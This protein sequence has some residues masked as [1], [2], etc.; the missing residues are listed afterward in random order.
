M[1]DSD[2]PLAAL[3]C[4]MP[5]NRFS[6]RGA[7]LAFG[8]KPDGAIVHIDD[9]ERGLACGCVCAA[10]ETELVAHRGSR[11]LHHFAH[12]AVGECRNAGETALHKYAKQLLNKERRLLLPN[13]TAE[14]GGLKAALHPG[15]EYR[16]DSAV[17]E[18]RLTGI[19]PDVIVRRRKR[20]LLVEFRVTHKCDE[21]KLAKMRG[22][23][24]SAIEIDL[25]RVPA[26][27]SPEVV[28]DAIL[29]S[30]PRHWL[31]NPHIESKRA[32]LRARIDR[33]AAA[34]RAKAERQLREA[35]AAHRAA[36][37]APVQCGG[38]LEAMNKVIAAG[39]GHALGIP[40]TGDYCFGVERRQWQA[41]V[42]DHFVLRVLAAPLYYSMGDFT[43]DEVR[44]LC[45]QQRLLRA[46]LLHPDDDGTLAQLQ[47]NVAEYRRPG[48]V[49]ETY[50]LELAARG[51]LVERYQRWATADAE[52]QRWHEQQ[53]QA[54]DREHRASWVRQTVAGIMEQVPLDEAAS[55]NLEAWFTS[56]VPGY[57]VSFAE[58]IAT[59]DSCWPAMQ[60]ALSEI[61][62]MIFRNGAIAEQL[63]G[64]PM[65]MTCTR[66]AEERRLAAERRQRLLET[67]ARIDAD[68]RAAV[69]TSTA[70]R[71]FSADD[72]DSWAN[73]TILALQGRT[74]VEAARMSPD[75]L[76]QAL[77][78]ADRERDRRIAEFERETEKQ[79]WKRKLNERANQAYR[80][81]DLAALFQKTSH[82]RLGGKRPAD[83]VVDKV[84]LD[85]CL[86]LLPARSR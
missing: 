29:W 6:D 5:G 52:R 15:G 36:R 58:A 73:A 13:Q 50:L 12:Y 31:F 26:D 66:L 21:T 27:A 46:N 9:V 38:G 1:T 53:R 30:A 51:I 54:R 78:A 61:E 41:V 24:I 34:R 49:L 40:I 20:E 56:P 17:L 47:L 14:E 79:G 72:G 75:G 65:G 55:F 60:R 37:N 81:P 82:P 59:D 68:E 16:F 32:E 39:Y 74:P 28:D 69:L 83:Y 67:A 42:F 63:L 62:S 19:V 80:D 85:R 3:E 22:L 57:R 84:S 7:R 10:C 25:S 11:V 64:L 44:R 8:Q 71:Y 43:A 35:I 76:R 23:G 70:R 4:D 33:E 2:A 86:Q 77:A 48:Q 45:Q 18:K